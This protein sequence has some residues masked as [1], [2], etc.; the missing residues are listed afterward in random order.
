MLICFD[1]EKEL[2]DEYLESIQKENGINYMNRQHHAKIRRKLLDEDDNSRFSK[3]SYFTDNNSYIQ[4]NNKYNYNINRL[5]S[6]LINQGNKNKIKEIRIN[7]NLDDEND[8]FS[9]HS[10]NGIITD[11]SK[12]RRKNKIKNNNIENKDISKGKINNQN[13]KQNNSDYQIKR[14]RYGNDD[15]DDNNQ[16]INDINKNDNDYNNRHNDDRNSGKMSNKQIESNTNRYK[17]IDN[18]NQYLDESENEIINNDESFNNDKKQ[19][20]SRQSKN[21]DNIVIKNDNNINDNDKNYINND[22]NFNTNSNPFI[23]INKKNEL[24]EKNNNNSINDEYNKSISERD[25]KDFSQQNKN[26]KNDYN[27]EKMGKK[28]ENNINYP[29]ESLQKKESKEKENNYNNA[30]DR[31][32]NM[33]DLISQSHS[34]R[35]SGIN[36]DKES[37][38]KNSIYNSLYYEKCDQGE[39]KYIR[40]D[41]NTNN[42]NKI[43][44]SKKQ[45][46]IFNNEDV[47]KEER[48]YNEHHYLKKNEKN[49]NESSEEQDH[50][51]NNIIFNNKYKISENDPNRVTNK[52]IYENTKIRNKNILYQD[53]YYKEISFSDSLSSIRNSVNSQSIISDNKEGDLRQS[54]PMDGKR[55]RI[56]RNSEKII[57]PNNEY[58]KYIFEQIN[59]LRT[60]P[61]S[62]ISKIESAKKNIGLDKR[63]NYYYNGKQKV[64]L[65]NGVYAFDNTIKHLNNIKELEK[66]KYDP[67]LNINLPS[68]EEE[69]N[70]RKYQSDS[71]ELLTKN[72]I[73]IKS[74]WRELIK[75]P[76]ECF[77]LMIIDDSGNNCGFKR[78]DLLDP[79]IK[80]IGINSITI[81]KYFSCYIQLSKK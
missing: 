19:N 69:I 7:N 51:I 41:K 10:Y 31:E 75:D 6:Q 34:Y 77:L 63:N 23:D 56:K 58:D 80:S 48:Q 32:S 62:F 1:C 38:N 39:S 17:E 46:N 60:N 74:F 22:N 55:D 68:N 3:E 78:K 21:E 35:N 18:D 50:S 67:N 44:K 14:N 49:E 54:F 27:Q 36:D 73:K 8:K 42:E 25:K 61:K 11:Y 20:K 81:G 52:Y 16:R 64:L 76:E 13:E 57:E 5:E 72:E 33:K 28:G 12:R 9:I 2:K 43:N 30:E 65:N 4:C 24:S 79:K 26:D 70:N 59:I 37:E 40:K 71:V 66:L 29:F 47:I 45:K 53:F 15:N